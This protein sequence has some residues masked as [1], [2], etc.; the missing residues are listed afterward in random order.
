MI[1]IANSIKS[2]NIY[3]MIRKKIEEKVKVLAGEIFKIPP[4]QISLNSSL[5]F[6]LDVDSL[7]IVELLMA[8]ENEFSI[9]FPDSLNQEINS[10]NDIIDYIVESSSKN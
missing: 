7:S 8:V 10:L 6:E 1:S 3:Y 9:E 5:V 2:D 4:E